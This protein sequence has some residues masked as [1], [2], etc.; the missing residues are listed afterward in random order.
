MLT[1]VWKKLTTAMLTLHVQTLMVHLLA[2]VILAIQEMEN[3]AKV[4]LVFNIPILVGA[5]NLILFLDR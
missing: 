3:F 2:H 4:I 1:N 5:V